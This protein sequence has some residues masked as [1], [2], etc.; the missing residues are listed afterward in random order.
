MSP[1][2]IFLIK[3]PKVCV[4]ELEVVHSPPLFAHVGKF[5]SLAG[6]THQD[7]E[8]VGEMKPHLN[9]S[10]IIDTSIRFTIYFLTLVLCKMT[11]LLQHRFTF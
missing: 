6:K 5:S 9:P 3:D 7:P 8:V 2:I 4:Q 11:R 1:Q 10:A